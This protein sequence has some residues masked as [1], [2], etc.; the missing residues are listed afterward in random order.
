M[1]GICNIGG[2]REKKLRKYLWKHSQDGAK[3]KINP[4]LF[5]GGCIKRLKSEQL[6]NAVSMPSNIGS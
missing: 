5:G 3:P 6:L 2:Y 4:Y 1:Y